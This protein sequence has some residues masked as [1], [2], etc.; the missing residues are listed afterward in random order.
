MKLYVDIF[1]KSENLKNY[2]KKKY[3][4]NLTRSNAKTR[5]SKI[6]IDF[7]IVSIAQMNCPIYNK[8]LTKN[9]DS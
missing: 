5:F 1:K 6:L 3:Y 8:L 9:A 2:D 7:E 4:F